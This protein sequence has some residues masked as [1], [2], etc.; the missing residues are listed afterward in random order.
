[1]VEEIEGDCHIK[2]RTLS[3]MNVPGTF[4]AAYRTRND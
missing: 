4:R 3:I 2:A 1:M